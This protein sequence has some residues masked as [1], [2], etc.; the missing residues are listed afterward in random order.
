MGGFF[1]HFLE[2]VLN[3]NFF[4]VVSY[5]PEQI[6][7]NPNELPSNTSYLKAMQTGHGQITSKDRE[8]L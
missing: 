2:A 7:W 1:K 3:T 8:A 6:M 5:C 4:R